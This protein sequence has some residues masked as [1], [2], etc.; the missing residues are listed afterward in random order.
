MNKNF[1]KIF[2]GLLWLMMVTLAITFWMSIKYGFNILSGAHWAY[3]SSLQANRAQIKPGF[4]TSMIVALTVALG[5]LYMLVR[6][7]FRKINFKKTKQEES[8]NNTQIDQTS[9]SDTVIRPL[10]PLAGQIKKDAPKQ[11]Y[12]TAQNG[13]LPTSVGVTQ[14]AKNPL[15]TEISSIFDA[16]GYIMK[17]C[18]KIGKLESPVVAL[19]YNETLWIASSNVTP[20]D[21]MNAIG[22]IMTIFEDTLGDSA[23]DLTLRGCIVSPSD[24][25]NPNPETIMTFEN[26]DKF[27]EFIENNKNTLP[28]EHD[29]ELFEAIS[30]YVSTVMNHI[31]K[32]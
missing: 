4:Y 27:K 31:G 1:E 16:A 7:R 12:S 3:L 20:G 21:V 25:E 5:G 17:P 9:K 8:A 10:S 28:P 15:G 29:A 22:D 14:P 30:T 6:P 26:I 18:K 32:L 24:A 19:G 11:E 2:L 23:N 13:G